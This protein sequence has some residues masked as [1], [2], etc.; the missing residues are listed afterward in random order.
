MFELNAYLFF[1]LKGKSDKVVQL[2]SVNSDFREVSQVE[3]Q[4]LARLKVNQ[5]D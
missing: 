3:L 2:R 4:R 5:L 1:H